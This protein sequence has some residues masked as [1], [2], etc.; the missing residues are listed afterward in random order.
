MENETKPQN[1]A[2][3]RPNALQQPWSVAPIPENEKPK[4]SKIDKAYAPDSHV[5]EEYERD[6][7]AQFT[8]EKD[9]RLMH[10]LITKYAL[11]G[12][13]DNE[14]NGHFYMTKDATKRVTEEVIGTHFGFTGEK[15][16]GMVKDAMTTQWPRYDNLGD[17]FVD[18]ERVPV[19]LRQVVGE[20]ET[21]IGL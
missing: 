21:A 7:P 13:T 1:L 14:P 19:F 10:S 6:T 3:Y 9:D 20:V 11:E 16:D 4:P 8:E 12:R 2:E 17:G 15:R 18:V 5:R